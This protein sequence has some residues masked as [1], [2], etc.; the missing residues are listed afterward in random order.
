MVTDVSSRLVIIM[1]VDDE[2]PMFSNGLK[3]VI[4]PLLI[5][6]FNDGLNQCC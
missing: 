4:Q 1:V 2:L 6:E 3:T 5:T